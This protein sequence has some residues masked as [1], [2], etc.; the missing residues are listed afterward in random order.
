M[1]WLLSIT[2]LGIVP[3]ASAD[4]AV[5]DYDAGKLGD[6]KTAPYV[7][8]GITTT[9]DAGHYEFVADATGEDGDRAFNLDDE[10]LGLSKVTVT[11]PGGGAFDVMSLDVIN[12]ADTSGEYT[13]SAVGGGGG[14]MPAPIVAGPVSFGP[15]FAGIT[16]LVVTQNSPG[17]F[18]FDDLTV[19]VL[20]EPAPVP[21]LV[22]AAL[23]LVALGRRRARA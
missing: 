11:A 13:I 14:S 5:L 6:F 22:T 20:P 2:L 15:G 23:A 1:R 16:A 3:A 18:T 10:N 7:E 9:V 17:S 4:V 12:P 8:N 21:A 19:N